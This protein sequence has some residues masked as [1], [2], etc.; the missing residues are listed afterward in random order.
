MRELYGLRVT[1]LPRGLAQGLLVNVNQQHVFHVSPSVSMSDDECPDRHSARKLLMIGLPGATLANIDAVGLL[2][3]YTVALIMPAISSSS[4][5]LNAAPSPPDMQ[6][7][8]L[9]VRLNLLAALASSSSMDRSYI[10]C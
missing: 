4:A 5:C 2:I 6:P 8:P 1:L 10:H 7:S 3:P 9:F